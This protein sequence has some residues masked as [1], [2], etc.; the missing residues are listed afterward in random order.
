MLALDAGPRAVPARDFAQHKW[1]Y[2]LPDRG[3]TGGFGRRRARSFEQV[4]LVWGDHPD[5]PY[6][7]ERW[8]CGGARG[9]WRS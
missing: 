4:P 6:T 7:T 5:H 9:W 1:P 8:R 3:L 2:E